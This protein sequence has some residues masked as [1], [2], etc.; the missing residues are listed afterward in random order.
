VDPRLVQANLKSQLTTDY[1]SQDVNAQEIYRI[2]NITF[3][4]LYWDK[5]CGPNLIIVGDELSI[6]PQQ[7]IDHKLHEEFTIPDYLGKPILFGYSTKELCNKT[8][9][10]H[11]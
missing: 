8:I 10:G 1:Y 11:N 4:Q 6:S 9:L 5:V 3:E 2:D 7:V